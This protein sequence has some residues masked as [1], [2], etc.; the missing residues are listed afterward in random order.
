MY[1]AVPN[2]CDASCTIAKNKDRHFFTNKTFFKS[3][4]ILLLIH[5]T[6]II[7]TYGAP[8]VED[9]VNRTK[10]RDVEVLGGRTLK[11]WE[12]LDQR[13]IDK[14]VSEWLK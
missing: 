6:N 11:A 12:E 14:T 9:R 13:V 10:S 1:T 2:C 3:V 7:A 4:F 8:H 5:C